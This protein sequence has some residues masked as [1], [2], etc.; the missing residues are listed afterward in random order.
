M[1][2]ASADRYQSVVALREAL[3]AF[4]RHRGSV[5]LADAAH[6]RLQALTAASLA[7]EADRSILYSLISESRFG[8]TQAL[9]EWPENQA[10][11]EGLRGCLAAA[12]R[13]E[14]ANGNAAAARAL[15]NELGQAPAELEAA[16]KALELAETS[17]R[18]SE[19]RIRHLSKELDPRV[20]LRQRLL[21]VGALVVTSVAVVLVRNGVPWVREAI[22]THGEWY[23]LG[24]MLVVSLVYGLG[25]WW[26]RR[27]LLSTRV[28]R[29]IAAVF[30]AAFLGADLNRTL[31][32]IT[33]SPPPATMVGDLCIFSAVCLGAGFA[34]HWGFLRAAAILALGAVAAALLPGVVSP[35]FVLTGVL[36]LG[37]VAAS[38]RSWRS[39]LTTEKDAD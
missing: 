19:A 36:A 32:I 9:R 7:P 22:V 8:F 15:L 39:E 1:A 10:A 27:A 26:G 4:L 24:F 23:M 35:I 16:V 29:Q 2:N 25:L 3:G 20:S 38:W 31:A 28:N 11:R 17:R 33:G 30:G 13:W 37:A 34:L 21:L 12:A 6:E 14:V 18:A 5:T